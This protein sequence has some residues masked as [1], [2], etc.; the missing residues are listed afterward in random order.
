M[1]KKCFEM[2]FDAQIQK[3]LTNAIETNAMKFA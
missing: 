3:Q 2:L 1:L